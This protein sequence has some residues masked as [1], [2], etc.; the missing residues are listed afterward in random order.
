M[1]YLAEDFH[2]TALEKPEY[3][4]LFLA[5]H[6]SNDGDDNG[7]A[8]QSNTNG[9]GHSEVTER[10]GQVKVDDIEGQTQPECAQDHLKAE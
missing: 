8:V 1:Y 2:K 7:N 4:P 3:A 10:K 9:T 5:Y 6:D